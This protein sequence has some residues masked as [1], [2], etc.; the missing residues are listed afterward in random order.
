MH[1]NTATMNIVLTTAIKHQ[2]SSWNI[3]CDTCPVLFQD[4]KTAVTLGE[5]L[6]HSHVK[7]VLLISSMV[8]LLSWLLFTYVAHRTLRRPRDIYFHVFITA[9]P[10]QTLAVICMLSPRATVALYCSYHTIV[11]GLCILAWIG[12]L[13]LLLAACRQMC[14]TALIE[15]LK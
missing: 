1:P 5:S 2:A 14:K 6:Q 3:L 10:F 11:L 12:A 13:V 15:M 4:S 9:V 8:M 7:W